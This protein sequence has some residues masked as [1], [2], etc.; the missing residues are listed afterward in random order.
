[1]QQTVAVG[2]GIIGMGIGINCELEKHHSISTSNQYMYIRMYAY[3]LFSFKSVV[4]QAVARE[5]VHYSCKEWDALG[6]L[7]HK[8]HVPGTLHMLP[9]PDNTFVVSLYKL[10]IFDKA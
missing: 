5:G 2:I 3:P 6:Q 10:D 1:M 7:C 4:C 9:Q 8:E